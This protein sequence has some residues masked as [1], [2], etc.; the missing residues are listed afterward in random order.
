MVEGEPGAGKSSLVNH[1]AYVLAREHLGSIPAL[2][3]T[4]GRHALDLAALRADAAL[5]PVPIL[6]EARTLAE[7]LAT[8]K[9]LRGVLSALSAEVHDAI[10]SAVASETIEAG[11]RAGRYF[12]LIDSLD[13]VPG[14]QGRQD[15]VNAL[16]GYILDAESGGGSGVA[17]HP[18]RVVLTTRP[19]TYLGNVSFGGL[20]RLGRPLRIADLGNAEVDQITAR[21]CALLGRDRA[22]LDR[23]RLALGGARARHGG[24][25]LAENPLLLVATCFV[26]TKGGER[27]PAST[28]DLYERL[29]D[30]LILTRVP[31]GTQA[32]VRE[33]LQIVCEGLQRAGGT[34]RSR[35]DAAAA[36]RTASPAGT[37]TSLRPTGLWSS[38][39]GRLA[40]FASSC[41]RMPAGA[42]PSTCAP[43]I[44]ASRNICAPAG[45]PRVRDRYARRRTRSS[46]RRPRPS[47]AIRRGRGSCAFWSASTVASDGTALVSTSSASS[48]TPSRKT[49]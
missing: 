22:Y 36:L 47:S 12:V 26:Y 7:K 23:L 34:G 35:A 28:A 49:G 2:D 1:V 15:V 17:G 46:S 6:I 13:E 10:G 18:S 4:D 32:S 38:S 19:G 33:D 16:E 48:S 30:T 5:L 44:G 42:R 11:L 24:V 37:P 39:T 45:L 40:S 8:H 20:G 14:E 27:L 21:W 29:V 43:G 3:A 9:G 25:A 31:P 41:E